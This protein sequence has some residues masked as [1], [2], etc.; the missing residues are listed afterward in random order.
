MV[1]T[2]LGWAGLQCAVL[3]HRGSGSVND[4]DRFVSVVFNATAEH[5]FTAE[6][7]L[8]YSPSPWQSRREGGEVG[9]HRNN[10]ALPCEKAHFFSSLGGK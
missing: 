2:G 10:N 1:D 9:I 6:D 8:L 7:S 3:E 4:E 5:T